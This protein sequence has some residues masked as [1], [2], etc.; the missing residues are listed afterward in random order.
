M[1][2]TERI[3]AVQPSSTLRITALARELK[4]QGK[5][6]IPLAAGEPD[7]DTPEPVKAAAVRAIQEGF[8]KYT[9][10]TGTPEL[11][12][13][14]SR[15]LAGDR[16][17]TYRPEQI[18]VTCGAKQA[19]YNLLQ[20]LVQEGDE[21]LIL[22][23]YWVSYPEMVR[24][25]G[26]TPVEIRTSPHS[27]FLP[28]PEV[29]SKACTSRTKCLILNSPSN[30]TGAVLDEKLLKEIAKVAAARGLW[31]ISD[32]IYSQLVYG[33]KHYS[34]A[35]VS[36]DLYERT[37]VVDGVSKAYSMTGWRIGYLAGPTDVVQAAARLQDHST[38]CPSSIS[39]RAALAALTGDQA[40]VKGMVEEFRKRRD[41]IVQRL[42]AMKGISFVRPEGAFYCFIDI[43]SGGLPSDVFV[44]RFL[45]EFQ[46]AVIPGAGFGWDTFI[47]ISFAA[48]M[49]ELSEGLNRLEQFIGSLR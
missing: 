23:P 4:A 22:S 40:P 28:D 3:Q 6:V 44:E 12:A 15:T 8:T 46:V 25:A 34:I 18:A 2:L 37:A 36:P 24:L 49:E 21:V 26:A 10:T 33:V 14:I 16:G 41:F 5:K 45:K 47:R 48:S 30:P 27:G 38:S 20:V 7:F 32:E 39:Q 43:S 42:S 29:L 1:T 31:V 9:P 13:A 17:L 19:I 35:A 11:K